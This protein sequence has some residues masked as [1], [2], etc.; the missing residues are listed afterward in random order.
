MV[1]NRT[2]DFLIV[3]Y[4][5]FS[6]VLTWFCVIF[7]GSLSALVYQHTISAYAL[8]CKLMLHS[9]GRP[10]LQNRLFILFVKM[11]VCKNE[12]LI[13]SLPTQIWAQ[14]K[15]GQ[16]ANQ[17]QMT[18][19]QVGQNNSDKLFELACHFTSTYLQGMLIKCHLTWSN[20]SK[21]KKQL[22][23]TKKECQ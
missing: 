9:Q 13:S 5:Y 4:L 6:L 11:F 12:N 3:A 21:N 8:P 20:M 19:E 22:S 14:Q 17:H 16:I 23:D 15:R 10:L 18:I 2:V 1:K 7:A